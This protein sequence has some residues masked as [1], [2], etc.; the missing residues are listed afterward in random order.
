MT[1]GRVVLFDF[2]FALA[3]A[4]EISHPEIVLMS[5]LYIVIEQYDKEFMYDSYHL[6][7]YLSNTSGNI[8]HGT[9]NV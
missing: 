3:T 6:R 4:K 5:Q 8:R 1:D 2:G 7:C 9:M